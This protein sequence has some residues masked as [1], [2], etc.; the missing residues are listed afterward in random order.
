ME[1]LHERLSPTDV[2]LVLDKMTGVLFGLQDVQEDGSLIL[3]ARESVDRAL[4]RH[5]EEKEQDHPL[6]EFLVPFV[7]LNPEPY[8]Y[9]LFRVSGLVPEKAAEALWEM[10]KETDLC[11]RL[12]RNR[13]LDLFQIASGLPKGDVRHLDMDFIRTCEILD[14]PDASLVDRAREMAKGRKVPLAEL[15]R[16]SIL[17]E[18]GLDVVLLATN[19]D[20]SL[21]LDGGMTG[22]RVLYP[23]VQ[24]I[25]FPLEAR[26]SLRRR[27]GGGWQ[28]YPHA[29]RSVERMESV[30]GIQISRQDRMQLRSF[31]SLGRTAEALNPVSREK[32]PCLL[33]VDALNQDPALLFL[34]RYRLPLTFMEHELSEKERESLLKGER[35]YVEDLK[36]HRGNLFSAWVFLDTSRGGLSLDFTERAGDG[37]DRKRSVRKLPKKILGVE[38]TKDQSAVL[39]SGGWIYLEDMTGKSG[40][41]FS[42]YLRR[43]I[44]TGRLEFSKTPPALRDFP[45]LGKSNM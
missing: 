1:G 44:A 13:I 17:R 26:L 30:A 11:R 16:A 45:E 27:A 29:V 10:I 24:G 37:T 19:N 12:V 31:R 41:A 15:D 3:L 21:L 28:I 22:I 34:S 39:E 42:S 18:W 40:R 36:S 8:R 5:V 35:V 43:D 33:G 14:I 7:T 23:M 9:S 4:L 25:R 2:F 38:L 6:P 20:L 32:E